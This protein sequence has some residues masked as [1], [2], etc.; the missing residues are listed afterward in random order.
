MQSFLE[1]NWLTLL[2]ILIGLVVSYLF[3]RLQRKDVVSAQEERLKHAH[4]E[5]IDV[6]ETYIINKQ[7]LSDEAIE[8]LVAAS[9][10]SYRVRLRPEFSPVT[11][12]QDV[13]LRLQRSR[14]LD[15]AQKTEYAEKIETVIHGIRESE[16]IVN[17]S[18]TDE[19]LKK[20][21][22]TLVG[23]VPDENKAKAQEIIQ[24]LPTDLEFRPLLRTKE[25][26]ASEILPALMAG[27][28]T[29]ASLLSL[30]TL[31]SFKESIGR[32]AERMVES[33]L[34]FLVPLAIVV[35]ISIQAL[36]LVRRINRRTEDDEGKK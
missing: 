18:F 24:S 16:E 20:K 9:E 15:I 1:N 8:N 32:V 28:A 35:A 7:Q 6:I 33:P 27:L 2:S 17:S 14:H 34:T 21:L 23:L 30:T 11:L 36:A 5:L 19:G 10:R 13:A 4:E 26:L 22:Q 29:V 12:L 3:Y 25:S 31:S